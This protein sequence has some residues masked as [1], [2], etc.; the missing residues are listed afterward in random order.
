MELFRNGSVYKFYR[1]K[2]LIILK[3][4]N[5]SVV[6]KKKKK[7]SKLRL[8]KF[9]L[10]ANEV[11]DDHHAVYFRDNWNDTLLIKLW[12]RFAE[13]RF[14]LLGCLFQ[15][16]PSYNFGFWSFVQKNDLPGEGR[17]GGLVPRNDVLTNGFIL[18]FL[19]LTL[20]RN[21]FKSPSPPRSSEGVANQEGYLRCSSVSRRFDHRSHFISVFIVRV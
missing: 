15:S 3:Q 19:A 7:N 18:F 6:E 8:C 5:T 21:F 14:L 13:K 11:C 4:V 17:H 10:Y 12:S 9:S 16:T 1:L 20:P 2:A